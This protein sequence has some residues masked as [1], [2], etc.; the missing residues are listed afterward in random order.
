MFHLNAMQCRERNRL[1]S[2]ARRAWQG[3]QSGVRSADGSAVW[4][5]RLCFK[6]QVQVPIQSQVQVVNKLELSRVESSRVG[7]GWVAE[8]GS[9][10]DGDGD[11]DGGGDGGGEESWFRSSHW[12]RGRRRGRGQRRRRE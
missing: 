12:R 6:L 7:L 3:D 10:G 5:L 8:D 1:D 4:N 2:R 11:G 9:D